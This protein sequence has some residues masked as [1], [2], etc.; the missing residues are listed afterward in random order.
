[1]LYISEFCEDCT[2]ANEIDYEN[3]YAWTSI[4]DNGHVIT[5]LDFLLQQRIIARVL[6]VDPSGGATGLR[7]LYLLFV[8]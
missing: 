6:V 1:M 2:V 8:F 3:D 5:A 4:H 7:P